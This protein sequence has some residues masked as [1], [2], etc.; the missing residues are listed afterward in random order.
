MK[1]MATLCLTVFCAM[2]ALSTTV[3]GR[4]VVLTNDG[5]TYSVK[6]QF[7]TDVAMGMG[8]TTVKFSFD[9][10]NLSFPA[11]P[12][13]GVDYSYS[14]FSGG[15]YSPGSITVAGNILSIN[16]EYNGTAGSGTP[17]GTSYTDVVTID[18]TTLIPAGNSNLHWTQLEIVGDD[19][20][21]WTNGTFP[22]LDTSPLP[23]QLSGFSAAPAI[24]ANTITVHWS[25]ASEIDNYGF[26]VQRSAD[27]SNGFATLA[28]SF[29]AGHGTTLEA[30]TYSYVDNGAVP[31][32]PWYRLKQSDL[33]G[34]VHYSEPINASVT[35][36]IDQQ[37]APKVFAL[38]QN[39]PNPFNPT[40][41]IRFTVEN[42]GP[43]TLV[44][45]N[46][47]GQKVATLFND[48]ATAGRYQSVRFNATNL[49]S[50][51]YIYRL[52]SA[53]KVDVRKLVLTK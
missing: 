22:D 38:F 49:A 51:M 14:A 7:K 32:Q 45:Y 44:V 1:T 50:G 36:G 4:F 11:S 3:D 47:L 2:S 17:V 46:M 9:N 10:T 31:S 28:G 27:K 23:I 25:T 29:Q 30:H 16:T 18:F 12:T 15:S 40:T 37:V 41:M 24:Q 13:A 39:Y 34:T 19:Y 5:S 35:T 43:A 53:S 21:Q 8:G 48:I 52:Q 20:V 6:V 42:S 26:D 33:N